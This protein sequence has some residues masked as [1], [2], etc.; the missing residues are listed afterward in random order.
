MKKL[1]CIML[2]IALIALCFLVIGCATT[3]LPLVATNNPIG[4]KVGKA[5]GRIWFGMFGKA[6]VGIQAAARNGGIR[7]ISTVDITKK[8]GILGLWVRYEVTVTGD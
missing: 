7:T 5:S 2:M 4:Y 6:N 1:K 3:T 8:L